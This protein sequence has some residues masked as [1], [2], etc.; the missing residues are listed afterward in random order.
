MQMS[1]D[2]IYM[3]GDSMS[4]ANIS[5]MYMTSDRVIAE[6]NQAELNK[7]EVQTTNSV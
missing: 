6:H 5:N 2:S 4:R 1:G 3:S 7:L